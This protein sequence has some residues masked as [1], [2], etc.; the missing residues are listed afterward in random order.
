MTHKSAKALS[1]G[2][3]KQFSIHSEVKPSEK[4]PDSK[5]YGLKFYDNEYGLQTNHLFISKAEIFSVLKNVWVWRNA[6]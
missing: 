1:K 2:L 5:I 6:Q 4:D 3:K